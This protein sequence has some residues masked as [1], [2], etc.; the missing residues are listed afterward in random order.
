MTVAEHRAVQ[1]RAVLEAAEKLIL[2][3]NGAVPSLADIASEVGLARPSI[4]RYVSSQH[5]LMVQL[6]VQA[7]QSWNEQLRGEVAAAPPEPHQRICAYVDAM[8]DLFTRGSHGSLM[9]A[10]KHF[11]QAFADEEVQ[12]AHA[13][14]QEIADEFCPGVSAGDISLLNAAIMRAA[15]WPAELEHSTAT[16][17]KMATAIVSG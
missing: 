10:A 12:T 3:N 1:H 14:F 15:E 8:L 2:A 17:H 13:G 5:D 7:T 9:T 16:L 11:P 6:L 4:Y